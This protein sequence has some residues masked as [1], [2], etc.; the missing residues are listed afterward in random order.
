MRQQGARPE[1]PLRTPPP[2][3]ARLRTRTV[4]G[5]SSCCGAAGLP[6]HNRLQLRATY[7]FI[8]QWDGQTG[9]ASMS[10]GAN[11]KMEYVWTETYGASISGGATLGHDRK[12]RCRDRSRSRRP[13]PS[14]LRNPRPCI[15]TLAV[16]SRTPVH[17]PDSVPRRL[18][19]TWRTT[20]A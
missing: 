20:T 16:L 4:V 18:R 5:G 13:M 9:Y 14:W 17:P 8:D 10:V 1:L 7:H 6:K 2:L 11:N 19:Q 15:H 12:S 3:L